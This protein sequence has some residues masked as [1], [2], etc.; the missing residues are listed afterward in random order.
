VDLPDM[1]IEGSLAV[2]ELTK[3]H[4]GDFIPF[5]T[6]VQQEATLRLR[7][8]AVSQ[9]VVDGKEATPEQISA[10]KT[11]LQIYKLDPEG[12]LIKSCK[13]LA[14]KISG[15]LANCA[16]QVVRVSLEAQPFFLKRSLIEAFFMMKAYIWNK[17]RAENKAAR[18]PFNQEELKELISDEELAAFSKYSTGKIKREAAEGSNLEEEPADAEDLKKN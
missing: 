6:T 12:D 4:A 11:V 14:P 2:A 16:E 17:A 15:E 18:M 9:V 1:K 3:I 10:A 7:L 5:V 8:Q 13:A